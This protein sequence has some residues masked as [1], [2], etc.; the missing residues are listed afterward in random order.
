MPIESTGTGTGNCFKVPIEFT[1]GALNELKVKEKNGKSF[2]CPEK[3]EKLPLCKIYKHSHLYHV[4]R[5][6]GQVVEAL[7]LNKEIAGCF[8]SGSNPS[9]ASPKSQS[10]ELSV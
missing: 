4:N 9:P 1:N 6:H 5:M 2:K 10:G 7:D 3:P 8:G